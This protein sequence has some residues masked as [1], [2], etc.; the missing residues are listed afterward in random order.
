MS[1]SAGYIA[2]AFANADDR[3][4]ATALIAA[5]RTEPHVASSTDGTLTDLDAT[6]SRLTGRW[7][8]WRLDLPE[9]LLRGNAVLNGVAIAVA[10]EGTDGV[11]LT[12]PDGRRRLFGEDGLLA[13]TIAMLDM[14]HRCGDDDGQFTFDGT[15]PGD[16]NDTDTISVSGN[17]DGGDVATV[18]AF[19]ISAFTDGDDYT[20]TGHPADIDP[21]NRVYT[22]LPPGMTTPLI[23]GP[24][25]ARALTEVMLSVVNFIIHLKLH[26]N[27][28]VTDDMLLDTF[29]YLAK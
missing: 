1:T 17:D 24:V 9:A 4:R 3:Q 23:M 15:W 20:Y 14:L 25:Q 6:L 13:L 8:E 26:A 29:D 11:I 7:L 18:G 2:D 22:I 10:V 19:D 12:L 27:G 16:D 5:T 28:L 21:N